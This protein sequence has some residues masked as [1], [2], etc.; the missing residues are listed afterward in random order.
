[1]DRYTFKAA[2]IAQN[3][4]QGALAKAVRLSPSDISRM[5]CGYRDIRADEAA[6]LAAALGLV[7]VSPSAP[8]VEAQPTAVIP[9]SVPLIPPPA[10]PVVSAAPSPPVG[11]NLDDPANFTELPDL[12]L[13]ERGALSSAAHRER[14]VAALARATKVL[15]T[16]RVR[17][18]VWREW[19]QFER[20]IQG[21]L[22]SA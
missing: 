19:R 10:V 20:N 7:P 3:M 2:R 9:P 15:H 13:L 21:A 4:S 1:M 18:A 22:R 14:L 16:S 12:R 5:E 8:I 17:A 11:A 6:A